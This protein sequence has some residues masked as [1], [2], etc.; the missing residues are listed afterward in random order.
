MSNTIYDYVIIGAGLSGL[1]LACKLSQENSKVALVE[2][3]DLPGG[4]N[5][6]I[7][8]SNGIIN[9]GLRVMPNSDSSLK[10]L[11]F[12]E[13]ILELKIVNSTVESQP[14]TFESGQIK[15]FVGFGEKPPVSM[16]SFSTLLHLP[17]LIG[18]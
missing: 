5:K 4:S 1:T 8:F 13:S 18:I 12:L 9:N 10:A 15:P 2:S 7:S 3:L 11:S 14:V 17:L 6:K 16:K